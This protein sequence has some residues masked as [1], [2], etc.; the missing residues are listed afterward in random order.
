MV[1]SIFLLNTDDKILLTVYLIF[2]EERKAC[3]L[4]IKYTD[5]VRNKICENVIKGKDTSF[6]RDSLEKGKDKE[7]MWQSFPT[8]GRGAGGRGDTGERRKEERKRRETKNERKDA[9]G[10]NFETSLVYFTK[11]KSF[12]NTMIF[13]Y[14]L[15]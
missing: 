5:A 4:T 9:L 15:F 1:A 7:V 6:Q 2:K 10:L 12:P 13:Q 8:E 14:I 3:L 11:K